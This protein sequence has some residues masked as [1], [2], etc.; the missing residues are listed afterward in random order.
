VAGHRRRIKL[1]E[2]DVALLEFAAQHRLI[3]AAQ[4]RA[5]LALTE[6]GTQARLGALCQAGLLTREPSHFSGRPACFLIT[7]AGLKTIGSRLPTPKFD[8]AAHQHDVGLAWLYLAAQR[9]EFGPARRV[10]SERE[11]RSHDRR[12]DRDG[13]LHGVRLGGYDARGDERRHYP[14]LVVELASGH[15]VAFELELTGKDPRRRERIL[16]AYAADRRIDA[17]VYL[18]ENAAIQRNVQA[19]AVRLGISSRVLVQ[20]CAF[21]A[22]TRAGGAVRAAAR[23]GSRPGSRSGSGSR[24]PSDAREPLAR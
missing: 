6:R 4:A 18:A 10:I 1:G 23:S 22:A 11:M 16:S 21:P 5:V 2:R 20:R 9:G 3:L 12:A 17:V 19:S 24:T 15:R 7:A 13:P 14:D 8:L